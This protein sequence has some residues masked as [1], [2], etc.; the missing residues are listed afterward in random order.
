MESE[1]RRDI[2]SGD[3]ILIAPRRGKRTEGFKRGKKRKREPIALCPLE[4]YIKGSIGADFEKQVVIA[5]YPPNSKPAKW[6]VLVVPNKYPAVYSIHDIDPNNLSRDLTRLSEIRHHGPYSIKTG[7]GHHDLIITRSHD[8][9]FPDLSAKDA[10][11]VMQSFRDRYLRFLKHKNIAYVGMFHNFGPRAGATVYH[12]HYQILAVSVVPPDIQH[13]LNGST[14]YFRKHKK[15]VHCVILTWEK[16]EKKRV[17]FQNEHAV[18]FT[19]YASKVPFEVRIFPKKHY[20]Y[21]EETPPEVLRGITEALQQA[22]KKIKKALD[23]DY[24]FFIHTA[25]IRQKKLYEHYHWHI[26]IL[27]KLSNYAG[28]ELQTGMEINVVDPDEAAKFIR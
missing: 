16:K 6:R 1:L 23:P 4:G 28:F 2:V 17:I 11:T 13:S 18:A 9:A 20:P 22:L 8:D 12:P 27:P 15:C 7:F 21:F 19:P 26:E 24:N 10:E 3:W 14:K 25:P 5:S